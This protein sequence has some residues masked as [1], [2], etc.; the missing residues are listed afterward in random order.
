MNYIYDIVLNFHEQYYNFYE[1]TKKDKI[2]NITKIP[3]YRISNKNILILKNNKVKI[4]DKFLST[5]KKDNKNYKKNICLVSNTKITI[6][7]LFD[8]LGNLIKRSSL[9]YEEE[10]EAND[11]CKTLKT[12]NINYIENIQIPLRNKI[13][14]EIEKKEIIR[15][16]L[17]KTKD[18]SILKYLY[19]EY[20]KKECINTK[21]IKKTLNEE[22]DK[23]WNKEQNNI[24]NIIKLLNKKN[25]FTK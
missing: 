20:F 2:N 24:Y 5:I 7:L 14:Y 23:E 16:Y 19:Y 25:S 1:W 3:I 13:R 9:I 8:N 18:I 6:G 4:D 12:T 11:Y 21:E 22:L 17:N 10:D 15:N